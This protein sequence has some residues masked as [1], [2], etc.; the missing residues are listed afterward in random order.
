[1]TDFLKTFWQYL[2]PQHALSSA[3]HWLTQL[4]VNWLTPW[5][6][7]QFVKAYRINLEEAERSNPEDYLSFNDFFTRSLKVDAR[8][9]DSQTHS[10]VAPADG[11]ISQTGYILRNQLIQ[12]K[13]FQYTLEALLGGDIALANQF[14][15]G[16]FAVIYLSPRDYHRVHMPL[17]G[18]L[19][20]MM[21]VPG[22]LFA[23]NAA[24]VRT[25][26]ELFARNERLI[27]SFETAAGPMVLVMVGAIF[28]GSMETVWAGRITPP[29]SHT[30]QYW[31]YR[32]QQHSFAKGDE[33][34]RFNMGSTVVMIYPQHRVAGL[35]AH[36]EN[37]PVL[38]GQAI[39]TVVE[40]SQIS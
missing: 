35:T 8:P 1:M 23:V 2:V 10:I 39:A 27:L 34:G 19:L 16:Q 9:I 5:M 20:S 30:I 32:H 31:D 37:T 38:M 18:K 13:G 14:Y 22:D 6:I 4:E 26:P 36:V 25:V 28:V 40:K 3:M 17:D 33:I 29:Y 15:D 12:A 11:K 24:S 7:H 21:L